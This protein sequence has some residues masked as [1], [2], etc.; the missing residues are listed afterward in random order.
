VQ[1]QNVLMAKLGVRPQ[2]PTALTGVDGAFDEYLALF[3]EPLSESKREAIK[4]LF[5][6]GCAIDGIQLVEGVELEV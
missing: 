5:P 6:A 4:T 3:G 2:Q 1:A